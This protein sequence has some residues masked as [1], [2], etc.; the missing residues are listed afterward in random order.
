MHFLTWLTIFSGFVLVLCLGVVQVIWDLS[1][2]SVQEE[3]SANAPAAY[4]SNPTE[5]SE[6]E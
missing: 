6:T 2:M 5:L 1:E 3:G 4:E